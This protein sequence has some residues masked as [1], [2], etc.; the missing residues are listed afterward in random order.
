MF[1]LFSVVCC[2][3][4]F[5]FVFCL[6]VLILLFCFVLCFCFNLLTHFVILIIL[7][8]VKRHLSEKTSSFL[9]KQNKN[10]FF[11]ELLSIYIKSVFCVPVRYAV[12]LDLRGTGTGRPRD[13]DRGIVLR[14]HDQQFCVCDV[15]HGVI[16]PTQDVHWQ[17]EVGVCRP[18]LLVDGKDRNL[19]ARLHVHSFVGLKERKKKKLACYRRWNVRIHLGVDNNND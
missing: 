3:W 13:V 11:K 7:T 5:V 1:V 15:C 18:L 8:S 9:N 14:A 19:T 16:L 4:V 2:C 12:E 6:F 17:R 10:K